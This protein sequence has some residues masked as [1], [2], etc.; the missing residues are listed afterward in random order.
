MCLGLC[1]TVVGKDKL[2]EFGTIDKA[3]LQLKTCDF[4]P[5]TDVIYLIDEGEAIMSTAVESITERRIRIKILKEAGVSDANIKLPYYSKD[6]YEQI[7]AVKG[8]TYNLDDAGNIEMMPLEQKLIFDKKVD[9]RYSEVSFAFPKVKAGSVIEYKYRLVKRHGYAD[10]DDWY[11]QRAEAVRY[12]SYHVTIPTSLIFTLQVNNRQTV[13]ATKPVREGDGYTF[14]MKNI[15]GLRYEP[16]AAGLQDYLQRVDFQLSGYIE[17]GGFKHSYVT[18]WQALTEK[19]LDDEFLGFQIK[20]TIPA[21]DL[22]V[23]LAGAKN[24][25]EKTEM[26]YSYVQKNM[27]W[28]GYYGK[29]SE[30]GIKKAWDKRSGDT[31]DINLILLSLLR[32]A[33]IT[34]Y[35]CLVSTR[36]HGK[37]NTAYPFLD[38]FNALYVYVPADGTPYI[39]NAAGKHNPP[40]L[41]PAE[42]QFTQGFVV[43]EKK[44]GFISLSSYDKKYMQIS[45][46]RMEVT[47]N[48]SVAG[49]GTITSYDYAKIYNRSLFTTSRLKERLTDNPAVQIAVDSV[50]TTGDTE[51]RSPL[52]ANF[53]FT[54]VLQQSGDY[55]FLPYTMFSGF[56]QSPFVANNRQTDIDFGYT[57]QYIISGSYTLLANYTLEELPK[58]ITMIMP[59]TSIIVKRITQKQDNTVMYKITLECSRPQYAAEEYPV[60]KEF[61]LKLYAML[62]EQI[63]I[64][65]K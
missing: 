41:I 2:P 31:G 34:A 57:Q 16:Y 8:F 55:T 36:N 39:L 51:D 32:E 53:D 47:K 3:D 24:N 4:D 30:D 48:G 5:D 64:K 49:S 17:T 19:V 56:G 7:E 59:D 43:D 13:E 35:P 38:Q 60:I 26:I 22:K 12:S 44:G 50:M 62:N 9:S 65:K 23:K 29:Y 61:Y 45:N 46:I 52:D 1:L 11:F 42:V 18:T 27:D 25:P 58:N 54:G 63:V 28:N 37:I 14:V 6:Q 21:D 15:P 40:H 10:I 33:G 20:K